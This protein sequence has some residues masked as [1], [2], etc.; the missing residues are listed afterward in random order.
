[1][2]EKAQL[3]TVEI[4][5]F[6]KALPADRTTN[7]L[8]Q[9]IVRSATAIAANIAEGHGRF[10]AGAYRNHLSIARGS[11]AETMSWL[12]TFRRLDLIDPHLEERIITLGDEVMRMISAKM[13]DLDKETGKARAFREERASYDAT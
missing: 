13:I 7:V 3:L 8:V 5:R 4:I 6:T 1:M 2:W 9:Q 11:V 12:D 10:A